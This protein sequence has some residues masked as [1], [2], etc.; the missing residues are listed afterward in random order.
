[1]GGLYLQG[2]ST[3]ARGTRQRPCKTHAHFL[4][5]QPGY[6]LQLLPCAMQHVNCNG[7]AGNREGR[8]VPSANRL[9]TEVVARSPGHDTAS[10]SLRALGHAPKQA[11]ILK[12]WAY[13]LSLQLKLGKW[14]SM[15]CIPYLNHASMHAFLLLTCIHVFGCV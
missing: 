11:R 7:R 8:L 15:L 6:A 5:G 12:H 14:L 3:N 1:M 9:S 13:V 2:S 10:L 4:F